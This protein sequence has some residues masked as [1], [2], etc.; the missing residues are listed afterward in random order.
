M[1]T[2]T[3]NWERATP[4]CPCNSGFTDQ[5]LLIII[6]F[7]FSCEFWTSN[8]SYK[9]VIRKQRLENSISD[10]YSIYLILTMDAHAYKMVFHFHGKKCSKNNDAENNLICK[11][12]VAWTKYGL[13]IEIS[14]KNW[15]YVDIG[16]LWQIHSYQF[17]FPYILKRL[18]TFHIHFTPQVQPKP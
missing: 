4:L 8:K 2:E 17:L 5:Y 10:I 3:H 18:V 1:E 14:Q 9:S 16:A 7:L 6:L 11:N 13:Q 12:A 15:I